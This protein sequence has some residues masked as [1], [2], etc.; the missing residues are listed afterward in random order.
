LVGSQSVKV[1][2]VTSAARAAVVKILES[3]LE[4]C[5]CVCVLSG[6]NCVCVGDLRAIKVH[7]SECLK[8]EN[9]QRGCERETERSDW[10]PRIRAELWS[11]LGGRD[12]VVD[13]Q[14]REERRDEMQDAQRPGP[15][16]AFN[17]P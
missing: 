1:W 5:V 9:S 10:M 2:A 14:A 11:A 4:V 12:D 3:M 15:A 17:E 7:R 16:S 13:G 6:G 8:G